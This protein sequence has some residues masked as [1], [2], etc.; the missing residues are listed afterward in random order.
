[1]AELAITAN[2][3]VSEVGGAYYPV[4][5]EWL[6]R[7]GELI[8]LYSFLDTSTGHPPVHRYEVVQVVHHVYD[9]TDKFPKG[10]HVVTVFVKPSQS[11]V[12]D[13][14]GTALKRD[15]P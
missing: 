8:D 14:S 7:V 3:N 9:V 1:M 2:A 4:R 11:S 10:H 6:P 12:F 13:S 15:K 5:L